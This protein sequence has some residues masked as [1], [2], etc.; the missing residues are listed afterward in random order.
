MD[1]RISF[2][3]QLVIEKKILHVF[4]T[5][6]VLVSNHDSIKIYCDLQ[7]ENMKLIF[8]TGNQGK[9]KEIRMILAGLSLEIQSINEEH[10]ECLRVCKHLDY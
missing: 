4:C 2:N 1:V 8:A 5:V 10:N 7:E 9:M 3:R 6:I